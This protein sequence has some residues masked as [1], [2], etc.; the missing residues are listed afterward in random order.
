MPNEPPVPTPATI[1]VNAVVE[2]SVTNLIDPANGIKDE[3]EPNS[4]ET[5]SGTIGSLAVT[6]AVVIEIGRHKRPKK[7]QGKKPKNPSEKKPKDPFTEAYKGEI[8]L[9]YD[10]I[11]RN[12]APLGGTVTRLHNFFPRINSRTVAAAISAN[13]IDLSGHKPELSLEDII[14]IY[15][16]KKN[17]KL[18]ND[19]LK[20]RVAHA[21]REHA[22]RLRDHRVQKSKAVSTSS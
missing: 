4:P 22:T 16:W 3:Q 14:R 19:E 9:I 15:L 21:V 12:G 11:T 10:A 13:V 5:A 18:Y 6:D 1:A 8:S 2:V 17:G 7:F 20:G